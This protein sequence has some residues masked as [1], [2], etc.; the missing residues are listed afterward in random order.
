VLTPAQRANGRIVDA[1]RDFISG[2]K[3]SPF[4]QTFSLGALKAINWTTLIQYF[5]MGARMAAQAA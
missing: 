1:L 5:R 4:I 3:D 2:K